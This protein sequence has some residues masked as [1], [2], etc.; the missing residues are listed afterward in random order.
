MHATRAPEITLH[1]GDDAPL[2]HFFGT[3]ATSDRRVLRVSS[4]AATISQADAGRTGVS[5]DM[6]ALRQGMAQLQIKGYACFDG[7]PR[8]GAGCVIMRIRLLP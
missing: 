4:N 1:V 7:N 2:T 6:R 3:P 8:H 5:G